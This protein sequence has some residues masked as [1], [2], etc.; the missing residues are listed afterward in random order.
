MKIDK[1][2]AAGR[3]KSQHKTLQAGQLQL[4]Q[5]AKLQ[6]VG[7]LAAGVAHE[8]KNPLQTLTIGL[9]Y[10][11]RNLPG[12]RAELTMVLGDMREAVRRAKAMVSDL[13][14]FSVN[15]PFELKPG[16][17]NALIECCLSLL[18]YEV[19]ASQTNVVKDL[20]PDLPLVRI[21]RDKMEQVLLNL[22]IN[23]LQA[24]SQGGTLSIRTYLAAAGFVLRP[25]LLPLAQLGDGARLVVCEIQDTGPGI[26]EQNLQKIFEPFFTT[27]PAGLGTGLGLWVVKKIVELHGGAIDIRNAPTGG[28]LVS[29]ALKAEP[30]RN[31]E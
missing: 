16:E 7:R 12:P 14:Q 1:L 13:L 31:Y 3:P 4:I 10:L 20:A 25:C 17:L 2:R 9:D 30:R 26:P 15:T 28:A 27:K 29:L 24:M 5:S 6:S 8:I 19:T 11:E 22:F 18:S 21:N 23:S